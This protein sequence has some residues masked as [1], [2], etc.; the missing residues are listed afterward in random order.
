MTWRGGT[1][2]L[3][4]EIGK[5]LEQLCFKDRNIFTPSPITSYRGS[6][7]L[8]LLMLRI[9]HLEPL[10]RAATTGGSRSTHTQVHIRRI[11]RAEISNLIRLP[12]NPPNT[13]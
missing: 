4:R 12:S 8:H 1:H 9:L 2:E 13:K 6:N 11:L 10:P 5:L 3:G 7:L